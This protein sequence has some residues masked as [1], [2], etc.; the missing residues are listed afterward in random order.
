MQHLLK[1]KLEELL[2]RGTFSMAAIW[3]LSNMASVSSLTQPPSAPLLS[4]SPLI[5]VTLFLS[6][7]IHFTFIHTEPLPHLDPNFSCLDY[8]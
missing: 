3:V 4:L 8:L 6:V 1:Q 7:F 2:R 5:L